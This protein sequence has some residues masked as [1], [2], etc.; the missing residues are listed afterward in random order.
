MANWSSKQSRELYSV[1]HWGS[2]FFDVGDNGHVLV[3]PSAD[4][5]GAAVDLA[6]LAARMQAMGLTLPV[7]VR[8][9]GILQQR[10]AR[11]QQAF[12]AAMQAHDY[13]GRFT[14]VYPIK[15]NQQRRV[16]E[17]ILGHDPVGLEAG[18]KPELLAVLSVSRQPGGI[19]ICN[20]Y[21]DSEYIR[22]ALIGNALGHRVY[23]VIEKLSELEEVIRQ[24]RS[25]GIA[26]LLGIRIRLASIAAGKWQNSGGDQSKFG[27]SA[28]AVIR[29]IARL[30]TEQMLDAL[31][32][33]HFHMGSQVPN[34]HDLRKAMRECARFYAEL[35]QLGAGISIVDAGGGLGVDYEGTRSRH[36][37][38][39]NYSV[40]EYA[41]VLVHSLAEICQQ[42]AL[43]C[44]EIFTESGRAITAHH[45]VLV[46]NV[47]EAETLPEPDA[48]TAPAA[49]APGVI[50]DLWHNHTGLDSRS[51]AESH[52]EAERGRQEVME[53]F[54]LGVL[55]LSQRAQAEE[56]YYA[57]C[58]RISALMKA[59]R[60]GDAHIINELNEKLADKYFCNFSLFQ[61][62]PDAWAIDQIFPIMPLQRLDEAPTRR[63][64]VVDITCD[65]DGRVKHYVVAEGIDNTLP[66]HE[67]SDDTPYLLGFFMVGAYQEIL[68][69][70]HN[71]F[72]DTDSVNVVM[73]EDGSYHLEELLHGDKVDYVLDYVHFDADEL[74]AL[75][76][77]KMQTSELP[78]AQQ[79]AYLDELN[80]GIRGYTYLED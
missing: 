7:M 11:M 18:S 60:Q 13:N 15:V 80:E 5:D 30:R 45:A 55:S 57:T 22:L 48:L 46:C 51:L 54:N 76:E 42:Q 56:I 53:M 1:A 6:E 14:P 65:S 70:M 62:V 9:S 26:P 39:L 36:F 40:E 68:G 44:P 73:D 72:G 20:G 23:L 52:H 16:V 59:H 35:V 64:V 74:F 31:Q 38:S 19:I 69:D 21:K 75:L 12:E 37:C 43:P 3:R 17:D 79:Q 71:L 67:I 58:R 2:G 8:F 77:Q 33:L 50:Q 66:L 24:S 32:L 49:D 28:A 10:L 29:L 47:L 61:S 63:G 25:M 27:L 78:D 41:N 4:A 34:I